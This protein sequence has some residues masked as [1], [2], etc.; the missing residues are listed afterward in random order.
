M[1]GHSPFDKTKKN[2][3]KN[4]KINK[5]ENKGNKYLVN[6]RPLELVAKKMDKR[7]IKAFWK[8]KHAKQI[9]GR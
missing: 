1:T 3:S 2:N 7:R 6:H 4:K 5:N 8:L 9:L